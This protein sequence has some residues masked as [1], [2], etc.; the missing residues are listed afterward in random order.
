MILIRSD[1]SE[2]WATSWQNQQNDLCTQQRLRSAWASAQSDQSLRCPHEE[3]LGPQLPTERTVKTHWAHW[4]DAQAD[5]SYRWVH[6]SFCWFCHEVGHITIFAN[7]TYH[8]K[9]YKM[10]KIKWAMSSEFGTYCL[11]EQRRFRQACT[12]AQ[13]RLNLPCSHPCSLVRTSAAHSYKQWV[14]RNLQTESQIPGP[15]EWLG[16]RS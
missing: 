16:M 14:K 9:Q 11:C 8:W 3:T 4:V 13:S 10:L 1:K 2:I 12:S 15:S 6:R 5:L 7:M